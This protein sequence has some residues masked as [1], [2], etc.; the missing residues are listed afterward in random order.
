MRHHDDSLRSR[1][2]YADSVEVGEAAFST[3]LLKK[4]VFPLG[5]TAR[6][7]ETREVINRH[8]WMWQ[9]SRSISW[10]DSKK[11]SRKMSVYQMSRSPKKQSFLGLFLFVQSKERKSEKFDRYTCAL[12]TQAGNEEKYRKKKNEKVQNMLHWWGGRFPLVRGNLPIYLPFF[13][14]L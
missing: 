12:R 7:M 14:W 5:L 9:L 1:E 13:A 10:P 8:P 4:D 6:A 2:I 3:W 11:Q